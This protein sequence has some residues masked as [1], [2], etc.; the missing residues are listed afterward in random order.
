MDAYQH[1]VT[2][3]ALTMGASWASG[4]NLYAAIAMLGLSGVYGAV[5]LPTDLLVL[6]NPLVIFSACLM[7]VVEFF[8]DKMP[9]VDTAWDSLH[10]FIRIP[11]GA[12][13]AIGA[14]G[15][16]SPALEIA[17]GILGGTMAAASHATKA[18]GRVL[19]N[20][21]PEPF[22]NWVVSITEDVA[23]FGGLWTAL[24]HP[25]IFLGLLALFILLVIWLLPRIGRGIKRVFQFIGRLFGAGKTEAVPPDLTPPDEARLDRLKKLKALLDSG[26]LSK[27]EYQREKERILAGEP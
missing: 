8:V 13:L 5:Q 26:A 1:I 17:A 25:W 3:I 11:A 4:L 21:S 10:T 15:E 24:H 18:G 23:V 20:A 12:L 19:I 16:A 14:V 6:T 9:G 2:T 22:S 7:Y 27:A